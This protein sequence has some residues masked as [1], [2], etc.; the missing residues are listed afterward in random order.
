MPRKEAAKKTGAKP[1][2]V[3]SEKQK[4]AMAEGRRIANERRA[5]EKAERQHQEQLRAEVQA[6]RDR[7][8]KEEVPAQVESWNPSGPPIQPPPQQTALGQIQAGGGAQAVPPGQPMAQPVDPLMMPEE[9]KI[10]GAQIGDDQKAAAQAAWAAQEAAERAQAQMAPSNV[11]VPGVDPRQVIQSPAQQPADMSDY[12]VEMS[13]K[14]PGMAIGETPANPAF[15]DPGRAAGDGYVN[16]NG[17]TVSESISDNMDGATDE[18]FARAAMAGQIP[19]ANVIAGM[20]Q[21]SPHGFVEPVESPR[22]AWAREAQMA[23][24]GA[25]APAT[26]SPNGVGTQGHVPM[27][28]GPPN[29]DLIIRKMLNRVASRVGSGKI[30]RE[31]CVLCEETGV[32]GRY[33]TCDCPCHDAWGYVAYMDQLTAGAQNGAG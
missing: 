16:A 25:V 31:H 18:D 24:A 8:F 29:A 28:S 15:L 17:Q 21:H 2:R 26:S 6:R 12:Q 3:L 5:A 13:D 32:H 9:P 1:K 14:V 33:K 7:T 19:G 11:P 30:T 22:V 4:A 27:P 20:Q 23:A 10:L